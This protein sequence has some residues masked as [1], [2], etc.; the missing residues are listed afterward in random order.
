MPEPRA[1]RPY[2]RKLSNY[3][4]DKSLQLRYVALVTAVSAV[5]S[6]GLGYLIWQQEMEASSH[7]VT[8]LDSV[9]DD[10]EMHDNMVGRTS[11][12]DRE[13]VLRMAA[14][15]LGLM[16]VLFLYLVVMT[17]KVAGPLYKV[18]RYFD[19]MAVGRLGPVYSLRKKDMLRDF[20]DKFRDMH[21]SL[22]EQQRL[23][24][25]AMARFLSA[26][27]AAGV[28][29][30]DGGGALGAELA[31]LRAHVERRRKALA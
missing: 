22:R 16:G 23:D 1:R 8:A 2:R 4:L 17:H 21:E 11:T 30:D 18:S 6:G 10:A 7:V 3:L 28:G 13:L 14:A 24:I 19:E 12:D 5:I 9:F 20:Y 27:D 25:E 29:A 31:E 15:G 26:A